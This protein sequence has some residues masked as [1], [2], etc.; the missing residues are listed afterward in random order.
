MTHQRTNAAIDDRRN[1]GRR[2]SDRIA[3]RRRQLA[4]NDRVRR[5]GTKNPLPVFAALAILTAGCGSGSGAPSEA[6]STTTPVAM[7]HVAMKTLEFTP[8]SI[9]AKVGQTITWTNEDKVHHNVTYLSGPA[10]RSSPRDINP[11]ASFSITLTQPGTI[12]YFCTIHPWMKGTIVV[13]P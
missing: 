1:T 4:I 8:A 3:N 13:S 7:A 6:A 2:L 9:T 11:G 10:F 12:H 5:L